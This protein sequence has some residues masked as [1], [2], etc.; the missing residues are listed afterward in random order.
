MIDS[1]NNKVVVIPAV[2]FKNK[3]NIDWNEVE[4]YLQKYIGSIIEII[5]TKDI[6]HIGKESIDEYAG[7]NY[8]AKLR[9]GRAK[10][11]ANAS[12]GLSEMIKIA[13]DKR[14][15]LNKKEKHSSIAAQGWYYFT[16]RFAIPIYENENKTEVYNIY[17]GC[18]VINCTK[19]GTKYFYDLVDIKKE[20][21]TPLKTIQ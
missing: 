9:G 2:I 11:K 1:E 10:A 12:Q 8:T 18:L 17:R 19:H 3:Q 14:F 7:S 6:I 16:T 13:K 20:A 5:E 15:I 4:V 21:S